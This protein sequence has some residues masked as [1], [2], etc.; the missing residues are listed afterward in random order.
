MMAKRSKKGAVADKTQAPKTASD[1]CADLK[2]L[3][4]CVGGALEH[5]Q[6]L[7]DTPAEEVTESTV[8]GDLESAGFDLDAAVDT[9]SKSGPGIAKAIARKL[10]W[11][12]DHALE[13]VGE[14]RH[15]C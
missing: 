11:A 9:F 8:N 6:D 2:A 5:I 3:H 12:R 14:L 1:M 10:E 13:V 15:G 4:D 7:L